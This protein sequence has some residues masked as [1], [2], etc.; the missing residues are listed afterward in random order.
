MIH[1]LRGTSLALAEN[2][3]M[4][5]KGHGSY[6]PGGECQLVVGRTPVEAP[7]RAGFRK[8]VA[9]AL[10][11]FPLWPDFDPGRLPRNAASIKSR[12]RFRLESCRESAEWSDRPE[13]LP[14][15]LREVLVEPGVH[16]PS[17][18][19][20]RDRP[21]LSDARLAVWP[22]RRS[23]DWP[24]TARAVHACRAS[25]N[26]VRPAFPQIQMVQRTESPRSPR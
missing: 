17:P 24:G 20:M 16:G 5:L 26:P 9:T 18:L 12:A 19:E 21:S 25:R 22:V 13:A 8:V 23:R 6:G 4:G 15:A 10:G 3:F 14:V 2:V 7:S 11:P 1:H